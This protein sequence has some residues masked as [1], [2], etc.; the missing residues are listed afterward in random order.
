VKPYLQDR[1]GGVCLSVK[2]QPRASKNEIGEALGN[3]LK[4]KIAA[5]PV[6]SAANDAL[7]RFL[8]EVLSCAR[9]DVQLIRGQSSR[10]KQIFIQDMSASEVESRFEKSRG[11]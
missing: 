6:D 4:V 5:P 7:V 2:V 1:D 9:G 10:H 8:A 11:K 3:E